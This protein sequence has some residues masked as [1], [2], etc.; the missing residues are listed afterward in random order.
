MIAYFGVMLSCW[1]GARIKESGMPRMRSFKDFAY[2][3]IGVAAG[4]TVGR[5][6]FGA[7]ETSVAGL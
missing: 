3:A 2:F 1:F 5:V 6:I 7:L 4:Y